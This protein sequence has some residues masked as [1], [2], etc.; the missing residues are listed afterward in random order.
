MLKPELPNLPMGA[1]LGAQRSRGRAA[2]DH[3]GRGIEPAAYRS[4]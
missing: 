2:G 1:G 3:E 4:L